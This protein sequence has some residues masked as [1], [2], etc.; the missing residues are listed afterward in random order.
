MKSLSRLSPSNNQS[1]QVWQENISDENTFSNSE[2]SCMKAVA[3]LSG[4]LCFITGK[5]SVFIIHAVLSNS[6]NGHH[7][8]GEVSIEILEQA[9]YPL[10]SD[11]KLPKIYLLE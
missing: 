11:E 7:S 9:Y 4:I 3:D 8:S 2:R 1:E 5:V 10:V 6:T